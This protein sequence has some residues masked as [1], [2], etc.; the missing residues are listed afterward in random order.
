MIAP[1]LMPIAIL[2]WA[3][4]E[5][6]GLMLDGFRIPAD[7]EGLPGWS[8][9]GQAAVFMTWGS[10]LTIATLAYWRET[11]TEITRAA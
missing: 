7:M 9:W 11:R 1:L 4:V 5:F 8:F 6:V 10:S 3:N 2:G